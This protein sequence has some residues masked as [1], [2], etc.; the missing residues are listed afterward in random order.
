ML[1]GV[2]AD[3]IVRLTA[4]AKPYLLAGVSGG[5]FDFKRNLGLGLWHAWSAGVG[6]EL[7]RLGPIGIGA[8]ARYQRL[9]RQ[10]TG[11]ASLG[12][13]I[14]T[15]IG[16]RAAAQASLP[17][18]RAGIPIQTDPDTRTSDPLPLGTGAPAGGT[19]RS[20]LD[21]AL[22]AMGTPY[23]WGGT[24]GNGFDCSGLIQFAYAQ[25]GLAVP[26]RSVDQAQFGRPVGA[27]LG[28]IAAGDVLV[29]AREPGGPVSHVGLYLGEG[30]FIHSATGGTQI[31]RLSR[32]DSTGR[33]WFD[34]WVDSRR[35]IPERP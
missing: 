13:R 6:V 34:R 24:N 19:T 18:P 11:G 15:A 5:L 20:V 2:G 35:I 1:G 26:R 30:R 10:A 32:D 29:F 25:G 33:W 12:I 31:S 9:S 21:A 23:R 16:S 22:D 28:A 8:E 3:A 4:D 27:D 7:V 17:V 14:G